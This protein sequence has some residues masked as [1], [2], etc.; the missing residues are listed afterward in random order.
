[1]A[2]SSSDTLRQALAFQQAGGAKPDAVVKAMESMVF[3]NSVEGEYRFRDCDHAA[4]SSVFAVEGKFND[5]YK[6]YPAYVEEMPK[7]E[8]LMVPC[9]QTKC[10][11]AMKG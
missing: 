11:P 8:A 2:Q 10:E 9:G 7:P 5:T 1:M 3:K 4:I 6:F